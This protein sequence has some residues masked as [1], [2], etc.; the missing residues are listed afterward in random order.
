MKGLG[1]SLSQSRPGS[2]FQSGGV[3]S[4]GPS[5]QLSRK[6]TLWPQSSPPSPEVS[7]SATSN[8]GRW[9]PAQ[10]WQRMLQARPGGAG[11]NPL[12]RTGQACLQTSPG[13]A[14]VREKCPQETSRLPGLCRTKDHR[15][16]RA[17][18]ATRCLSCGNQTAQPGVGM[19]VLPCSPLAVWSPPPLKVGSSHCRS[20]LVFLPP[21][22]PHPE[23]P[24]LPHSTSSQPCLL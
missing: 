20:P 5:S 2:T 16:P 24:P 19:E 13:G 10:R 12:H 9:H 4:S 22:P 7:P 14:G 21:P 8:S 18:K 23:L 15:A 3:S 1:P 6:R 17:C 11:R